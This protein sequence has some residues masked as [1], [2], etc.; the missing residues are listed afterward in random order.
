MSRRS[1][2]LAPQPR[3]P[4]W[5]CQL[6]RWNTW[7]YPQVDATEPH[8]YSKPPQVY[9]AQV[10]RRAHC[11][12][13]QTTLRAHRPAMLAR[14]NQHA[15]KLHVLS[16]TTL[17]C[18]SWLKGIQICY[19]IINYHTYYVCSLNGYFVPHC[20]HATIDTHWSLCFFCDN[21]LTDWYPNIL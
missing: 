17:L 10:P 5:H 8:Y 16:V 13:L 18:V 19:L 6:Q 11:Q 12:K 3:R 15:L 1:S 14:D 9:D 4:H 2:A 21:V 7:R 20:L